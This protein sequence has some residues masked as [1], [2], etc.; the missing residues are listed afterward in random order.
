MSFCVC[1]IGVFLHVL[2]SCCVCVIAISVCAL[3]RFRND[4]DYEDIEPVT[5]SIAVC[6]ALVNT[7]LSLQYV[8]YITGH[9]SVDERY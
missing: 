5:P 8:I 2:F 1:D 6:H 9:A 7:C 4:S 3:V